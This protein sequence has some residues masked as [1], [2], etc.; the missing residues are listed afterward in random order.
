MEMNEGITDRVL[1][2]AAGYLIVSSFFLIE[3]DAR[4]LALLGFVPLVS[5]LFGYC[6]LYRALGMSTRAT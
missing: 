6:P 3:G 1:R 5:G 4:W 2:M